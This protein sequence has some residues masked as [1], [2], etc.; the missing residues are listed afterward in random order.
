[1]FTKHGIMV[2]PNLRKLVTISLEAARRVDDYRIAQRIG[3][4]SE[5]LRRLIDLGLSQVKQGLRP[6]QETRPD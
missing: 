4:E 3:S 5:A 1:M 6:K 2:D